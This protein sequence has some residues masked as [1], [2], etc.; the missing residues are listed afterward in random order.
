MK[1]SRRVVLML[2][3]T[4]AVSGVSMGFRRRPG[5]CDPARPG[6]LEDGRPF[7]NNCRVQVGGFGA[8]PQHFQ[9]PGGG[10]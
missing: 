7:D 5:D 8:T 1:R 10:G 2:M 9:F 4:A 3:G 6:S